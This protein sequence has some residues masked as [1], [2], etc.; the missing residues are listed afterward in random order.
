MRKQILKNQRGGKTQE[1][2]AEFGTNRF[3]W[4]GQAIKAARLV[5]YVVQPPD[6]E[7]EI[8]DRSWIWPFVGRTRQG[9]IVHAA[10]GDPFMIDNHDGQGYLKLANG[11]KPAQGHKPGVGKVVEDLPWSDCITCFKADVYRE[12]IVLNFDKMN[13]VEQKSAQLIL[14]SLEKMGYNEEEAKAG[15]VRKLKPMSTPKIKPRFIKRH[16]KHEQYRRKQ[17]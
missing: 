9:I 7:M 10:Q 4:N 14:E 1:A 12:A 11:G 8:S 2:A 3:K 13:E 17:D 16:L 5:N 15:N 6:G